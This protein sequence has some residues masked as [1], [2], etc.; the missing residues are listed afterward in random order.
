MESAIRSIRYGCS[1]LADLA[2][3]RPL[4][5]RTQPLHIAFVFHVERIADAST[6]EPFLTFVR[7]L[8]TQT[9]SRPLACVT[10]PRCPMTEA[11]MAR[12]G[13]TDRDYAARLGQLAESADL[14][15]H[16]HF[17]V[18]HPSQ[19]S[20]KER[21]L[22][23]MAGADQADAMALWTKGLSPMS[24]DCFD[25]EVVAQQMDDE[26]TWLRDR[27]ARVTAY[28]AGWWVLTEATVRLMERQGI[29]VDCSV[30]RNHPDTFGRQYLLENELAPRGEP[31][32]LPPSQSIVEI[33]SAFYPVDHPRRTKELLRPT[34]C[35]M[36]DQPLFLALPSHEGETLLHGRALRDN[37]RML[38]KHPSCVRWTSVYDQLPL[39]RQALAAGR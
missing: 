23:L 15:Y 32:F 2:A 14:G 35:H 26:L 38:L 8:E 30:R 16:G 11:Q 25:E 3:P 12:L 37:V 22:R 6:F 28:V 13:V 27:S 1:S 5:E 34:L 10:T 24:P 20:A 9:G 29:E 7:W 33:Q 21:C 31:A 36:P 39:A 18:R 4:P 19:E 17:Y